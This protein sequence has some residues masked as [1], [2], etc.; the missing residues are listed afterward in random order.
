MFEPERTQRCVAGHGLGLDQRLELP[1]VGPAVPV[2]LV[3]G[4]RAHE[5]T[6]AT[7]GAQIG[8]DPEAASGDVEHRTGP[9]IE[10][11]LRAL[12]HEHH[13]DVAR[14]VELVAP[15]LAHADD[16]ESSFVG[17][18]LVRGADVIRRER[19]R[20]LE[21]LATERGE[22]APHRFERVEADEVAG[23]DA[24]ELE[25]P[26]GH[27]RLGGVIGDRWPMIEMGEELD[28]IV[29]SSADDTRER[30]AG[31]G[32]GH[33]SAGELRI[34][35]EAIG[36]VA[37]SLDEAAQRE[38]HGFGIGAAVDEIDDIVGKRCRCHAPEAIRRAAGVI[39]CGRA[40]DPSRSRPDRS[41]RR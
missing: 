11:P 38:G 30:A 33:E 41:R 1:R 17:V 4:H 34:G 13:I 35:A 28:G 27:E 10:I 36:P 14:V 3:R 18:R 21:N 32:D 31:G 26:P 8:V 23:G 39:V 6:A 7:L 16:G 37:I 9:A 15:E 20:R 2:A 19:A 5:C 29:G 22:I 40:R 24:Q 12:A 25:V